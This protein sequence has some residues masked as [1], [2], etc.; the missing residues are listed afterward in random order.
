M[1]ILSKNTSYTIISGTPE[2]LA[3]AA[4]PEHT[5]TEV[6]ALSSLHSAW[7]YYGGIFFTYESQV[8]PVAWLLATYPEILSISLEGCILYVTVETVIP[9][10]DAVAAVPAVPASVVV[11][12]VQ[13][14]ST[15]AKSV[16]PVPRGSFIRHT[17]ASDATGAVLTLGPS[18]LLGRELA[19]FPHSLKVDQTGVY[20]VEYGVQINKL[21]DTYTA[22]TDFRIYRQD[23]NTVVYMV[24][25]G[26]E[27]ILYSSLLPATIETLYGFGYLYTSGDAVS[28]SEIAV[29]SVQ[30]SSCVISGYETSSAYAG[31][32]IVSQGI[33]TSY[34]MWSA[35]GGYA[36]FLGTGTSYALAS[37][38]GLAIS[39]GVGTSFTVAVEMESVP[40]VADHEIFAISILNVSSISTVSTVHSISHIS[41]VEVS[42]YGGVTRIL[43]VEA[44][45]EIEISSISSLSAIYLIEAIS[46]VSIDSISLLQIGTIPVFD[47]TTRTWVVN[48]DTYASSQY[49]GYGFTS[50]YT[51]PLTGKNYGTALDGIYE[52]TGDDDAGNDIDAL[53]DFGRSDLGTSR[54]KQVPCLYQGVSS[55]GKMLLKVDADGHVYT[56]EARSSS[57]EIKNHRTDI[58]KRLVGNY[59]NFTTMNQ[60]GGYFDLETTT[61]DP[62][63][64]SRK[65]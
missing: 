21:C 60:N 26:A 36:Y 39:Q 35:E 53:I 52:L 44:I 48:M 18:R 11:S 58:G 23:D 6:L 14:W 40:I 41:P 17:V 30:F 7:T 19:A 15:W 34:A 56:Y 5:I 54:K 57:A 45:S 27:S 49:D 43:S 9:A 10:T 29:G 31:Q 50:L 4:V 20:V 28:D 61:F 16:D 38:P 13:N 51:D 33:G 8:D 59:W 64:L 3:V 25:T 12:T 1:S 47:D 22:S 55:T 24:I 62:I 63:P 46:D 37:E 65:V 2:V 42:S 32:Q